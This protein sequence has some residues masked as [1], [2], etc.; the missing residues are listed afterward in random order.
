MIQ[1][2]KASVKSMTHPKIFFKWIL[3]RSDS[4]KVAPGNPSTPVYIAPPTLESLSCYN[5]IK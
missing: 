4:D 3:F 5:L 2:I 1:Y